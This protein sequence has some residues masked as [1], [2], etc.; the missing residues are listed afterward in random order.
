MRNA[1]ASGHRA[2]GHRVG[3]GARATAR[4]GCWI[5]LGLLGLVA[6][7]SN[8][9]VQQSLIGGGTTQVAGA[10][11]VDGFLPHPELLSPGASGQA[12]LVYFKPGTVSLSNYGAILLDPVTIVSDAMG[13]LATAS[14]EQRTT[15]ANLYYSDLYAALSQHCRLVQT[16]G[17]GVLRLTVALTDAKTTNGV[18]KT[19]ATYTPYVS[20]A[21]KAGAALFNSGAGV[22]SGTATSEAYATDATTGALLWQGV[23]KR[24]GSVAVVQN[25]TNSWN[26]V[27]NAMQGWSQFATKRLQDLGV[28][29]S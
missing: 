16:P 15:L 19:L 13:A 21:Y 18:V 6:G 12:A 20:V 17:P 5:G 10:V 23:D 22:F 7:C 11:P 9:S 27:D 14:P 24:A 25:T 1:T 28:C 26:D 2:L 4:R 8:Q 3:S 29:R